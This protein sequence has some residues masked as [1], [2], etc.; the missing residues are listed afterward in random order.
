ML[1]RLFA[2]YIDIKTREEGQTMVE[3]ALVLGFVVAVAAI[4]L[5][6]TGTLG[7]AIDDALKAVGAAL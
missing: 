4:A 6:S 5:V 2:M 3:Y 7:K 1:D